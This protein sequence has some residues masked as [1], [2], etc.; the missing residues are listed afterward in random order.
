MRSWRPLGMMPIVRQLV[1]NNAAH[2]GIE[3][4]DQAE[5]PEIVEEVPPFIPFQARGPI[6]ILLHRK[7]LLRRLLLFFQEKLGNI[8]LLRRPGGHLHKAALV[9]FI[10]ET[11]NP[12]QVKCVTFLMVGR[13]CGVIGVGELVIIRPLYPL[14]DGRKDKCLKRQ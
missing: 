9:I 13:V 11:M 5:V 4:K 6:L 10:R 1:K 8:C 3:R 14:A 7:V 12:D 2:E